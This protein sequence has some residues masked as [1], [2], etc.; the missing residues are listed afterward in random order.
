MGRTALS[1]S[2]TPSSEKEDGAYRT[3]GEVAQILGLP[4]HV[5]RFWESRFSQIKPVKRTGGRRYY[6]PEDVAFL[7]RLHD[8]LHRQGYTIRGVQ[9]LLNGEA[10]P[11]TVSQTKN[12]AQISLAKTEAQNPISAKPNEAPMRRTLEKTLNEL[13]GMRTWLKAQEET[14]PSL[15]R[16]KSN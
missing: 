5:L 9:Q 7:R 14:A 6:R 13:R 12:R 10:S 2:D 1:L 15:A 4:P 8:L 3:I 16:R 11:K